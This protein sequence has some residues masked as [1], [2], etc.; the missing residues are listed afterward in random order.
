MWGA[1]SAAINTWGQT[2]RFLLI[3]VVLAALNVVLIT[4]GVAW[5]LR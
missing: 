1:I 3:I 5:F 2:I 4:M